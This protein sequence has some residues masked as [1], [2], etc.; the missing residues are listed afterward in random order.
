MV[1]GQSKDSIVVN[2]NFKE[3]L[4]F[5]TRNA[6]DRYDFTKNNSEK[7]KLFTYSEPYNLTKHEFES[8][9]I[10]SIPIF[11]I[12]TNL[13]IINKKN[14]V[15]FINFE[16]NFT[17]QFFNVYVGENIVG[18]FRYKEKKHTKYEI[19]ELLGQGLFGDDYENPIR[20]GSNKGY[21]VILKMERKYPTFIIEQ[22][23]DTFFIIKN[24]GI[25]AV[26]NPDTKGG[27]QEYEINYFFGKILG[28]DKV[29]KIKKGQ[30][31]MSFKSDKI[32]EMSYYK[33]EYKITSCAKYK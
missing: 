33:S 1:Y 4:N 5:A 25:F 19:S 29:Q 9:E 15:E 28:Y 14:V 23:R 11:K 22:I 16:N 6:K 2:I 17:N 3:Y 18:D 24:N 10:T 21:M 31:F 12:N 26:C 7:T 13:K 27:Y 8:F 30:L 20:L 32:K